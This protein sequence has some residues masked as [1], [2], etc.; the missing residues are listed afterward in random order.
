MPTPRRQGARGLKS[1][2]FVLASL[3]N[4]RMSRFSGLAGRAAKFFQMYLIQLSDGWLALP[5]S[6]LPRR[7]PFDASMQNPVSESSKEGI[8][9]FRRIKKK[10][11]RNAWISGVNYFRAGR[12]EEAITAFSSVSDVDFEDVTVRLGRFYSAQAHRHLGMRLLRAKRPAAA[13]DH[14][15]EAMRLNPR[16]IDLAD[17]LAGCYVRQRKNN[18]AQRVLED[19]IQAHPKR[20]GTLVKLALL[21]CR[22]GNVKN[23]I[24]LAERAVEAAPTDARIRYCYGLILSRDTQY[25]RA[26]QQFTEA[27]A[28][29]DTHVDAYAQLGLVRAVMGDMSGA[30]A[31]LAV[32]HRYRP[33][34][35]RIATEL[36]LVTAAMVQKTD[37][38][39]SPQSLQPSTRVGRDAGSRL[40]RIIEDEPEYIEA[41][42]A[43]PDTEMDRTIFG[44]IL[45]ILRHAVLR[46]P[47]YADLYYYLSRVLARIGDLDAAIVAGEGA[48]ERNPRY[49]KA[50]IL[51]GR[52]Y[53][54]TQ[55]NQPAIVRLREALSAG[56]VYP[57]VYCLLGNLYRDQGDVRS[58]TEQYRA[59]LSLNEN[60]RPAVEALAGLAA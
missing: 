3:H 5:I 37:A 48:V 51:L 20:S 32:A 45:V 12:Y 57:D 40:G 53:G 33:D 38:D 41:L 47:E 7:W 30:A 9:R 19:V 22:E 13:A 43:L 8:V 56:A 58:A 50:L 18:D 26:A 55:R 34:D 10:D 35:A 42:L 2:T 23:A 60:Y 31:A 39:G 16:E 6:L 46:H 24:E 52:L 28:A 15:Q 4:Y 14:F 54:R 27:I 1:P 25:E 49:V 21:R 44:E 59:A 36:S 29:D 11:L 17:Y